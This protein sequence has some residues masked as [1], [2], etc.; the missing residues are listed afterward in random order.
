MEK[1]K[2]RLLLLKIVFKGKPQSEEWVEVILADQARTS[3]RHRE[4]LAV[5]TLERGARR[6][7]YVFKI[8][9]AR[10]IADQVSEGKYVGFVFR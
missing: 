9:T 4:W 2:S 8:K 10:E 1:F 7:A 6:V 3:E 5:L